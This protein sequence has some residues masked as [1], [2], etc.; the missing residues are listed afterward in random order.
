MKIDVEKLIKNFI[1]DFEN[2][3][4]QIIVFLSELHEHQ[5]ISEA[6]PSDE[7]LYGILYHKFCRWGMLKINKTVLNR[8]IADGNDG[9]GLVCQPHLIDHPDCLTIPSRLEH[10]NML[11]FLYFI[12]TFSVIIAVSFIFST[13]RKNVSSAACGGFIAV[14]ECI[15]MLD[16]ERIRFMNI[17]LFTCMGFTTT[18]MVLRP[19]DLD[20]PYEKFENDSFNS[21]LRKMLIIAFYL[22]IYS[23]VIIG[24]PRHDLYGR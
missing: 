14:P 24:I 8:V 11:Y 15:N 5:P 17:A 18:M 4:T 1:N 16:S 7:D 22:V 3:R 6:Q 9:E 20:V 2:L 13:K 10:Y 21:T 19:R 12:I 23:P